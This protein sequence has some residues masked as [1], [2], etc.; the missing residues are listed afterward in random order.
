MSRLLWFVQ[1]L[2]A[3]VFLFAGSIKLLAPDDVLAQAVPLPLLFVRFIGL[4]ETLG[5]I[6]LV[7]PPLLRIQPGLTALAAAGLVIIMTGATVLTLALMG[8]AT[9][10]LLPLVLGLLAAFV[11]YGRT[12]IAP[13]A[14]RQR[15][16]SQLAAG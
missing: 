15:R 10:A 7:L 13:V 16:V 8:D 1:V 4:C 3:L 12:R 11:V 9:G 5:A 6:G 14:P 2:L